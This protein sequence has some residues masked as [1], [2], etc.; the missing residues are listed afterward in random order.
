MSSANNGGDSNPTKVT[1]PRISPTDKLM[2]IHQT[3]CN[4]VMAAF[5]SDVKGVISIINEN[6]KKKMLRKQFIE[7]LKSGEI[8]S[9]DGLNTFHEPVSPT[10]GNK[11]LPS[12]GEKLKVNVDDG[13]R[14]EGD[15]EEAKANG[16][17]DEE[18][19]DNAKS[20]VKSFKATLRIV[21]KDD[22]PTL[23]INV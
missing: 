7:K 5:Q 18:C 1:S 14:N 22:E 23:D 20:N 8:L 6:K 13:V 12:E 17:D 10:A 16:N 21:K 19:E 11:N 4:K 2:F 15:I 3:Y 9:F